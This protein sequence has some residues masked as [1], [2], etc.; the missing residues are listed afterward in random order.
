VIVSQGGRFGGWA[1]H[2]IDGVLRYTYNFHGLSEER[3]LAGEAIA[4]GRHLVTLRFHANDGI[5]TGGRCELEVDGRLVGTGLVTRTIA[6]QISFHETLDVGD[7]TGTPVTD[8]GPAGPRFSG[9]I[10]WVQI[11]ASGPTSEDAAQKARR[12]FA[13]Q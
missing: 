11:D 10:D 12:A 5:G 1:F 13:S 2:I 3:V 8:Y 4:A 9:E 6:W 7:D